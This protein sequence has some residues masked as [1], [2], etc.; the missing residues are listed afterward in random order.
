MKQHY[1]ESRFIKWINIKNILSSALGVNLMGLLMTK[2]A[3]SSRIMRISIFFAKKFLKAK[4]ALNSLVQHLLKSFRPICPLRT[5]SLILLLLSITTSMVV[6]PSALCSPIEVKSYY[7]DYP[8]D[9]TR[10]TINTQ[11]SF[12]SGSSGEWRQHN[13]QFT[14]SQ[15][16]YPTYTLSFTA[17]SIYGDNYL[18]WVSIYDSDYRLV[19]SSG[20]VEYIDNVVVPSPF[21]EGQTTGTVHVYERVMRQDHTSPPQNEM[22]STMFVFRG[23]FRD[24]VTQ[25]E[26]WNETTTATL[27]TSSVSFPTT[28]VTV[29]E[30]E[31]IPLQVVSHV[32]LFARLFGFIL[33]EGD[34]MWIVGASLILA[35]CVW[36]L[37][38]K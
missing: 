11:Y 29:P 13:F 17:N 37:Y 2:K 5:L 1:N 36:L 12:A 28:S 15:P 33:S 27:S 22:N 23:Q 31:D 8:V 18:K 14:V 35:F 25:P 4:K 21:Q 10:V 16:Y 26:G 9:V 38:G 6:F 24:I 3:E 32:D 20:W 30:L 34:L 7:N 19:Y